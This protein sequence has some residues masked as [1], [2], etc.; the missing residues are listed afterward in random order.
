MHDADAADDAADAPASGAGPFAVAF[1]T[2]VVPDRWLRK[3]RARHP[4]Q[5]LVTDFV[6]QAVQLDGVRD[7]RHQ[8]AF[9]R[10]PVDRD[11]LHLIP[12]YEERPVVVVAREHP[13]AAYD[14]IDVADLA[15][16]HLLQDPDE[17]PAWRDL[18]TEVREGTRHPVPPM[19]LRQAV[20][21][22]A[23][24]AGVLVV[25]MAVA[26]AHHRKDV[27]AVPVTGVPSTQVGLAWRRDLDDPR[28]EQ[29]VGIVRGRTE[30]SSRGAGEDGT[31]RT[32]SSGARGSD[33]AGR[34]KQKQ[35]ARSPRKQTARTQAPRRGRPGPRRRGGR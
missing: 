1:V 15:D 26:R 28:V 11:G 31:A 2:G 30:R 32:G 20:E 18:A 21:S 17:V 8:M 13:V 4:D 7:G 12:L 6:D 5:P 35:P 19:T 22:V 16:E 9:V 3:G 24:D 23:A 33:G 27:V 14:E 10:L 34:G 29:L 25:P